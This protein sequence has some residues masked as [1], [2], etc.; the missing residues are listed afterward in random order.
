MDDAMLAGLI[1]VAQAE[2]ITIASAT[3]S[4]A[5]PTPDACLQGLS[6][7][8]A[9]TEYR[10]QLSIQFTIK[11]EVPIPRICSLVP[12][13]APLPML[14]PP[15]RLSERYLALKLLGEQTHFLQQ[16]DRRVK[17]R[18]KPNF[19]AKISRGF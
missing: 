12:N 4:K 15:F 11:E 18:T 17:S 3:L 9:I 2:V 6:G 7:M 14:Q 10:S 19:A 13:P 8:I 1:C 5:K 16:D